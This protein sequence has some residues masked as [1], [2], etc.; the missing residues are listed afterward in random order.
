M[1][2]IGVGLRVV[3][4]AYT[5]RITRPNAHSS[6]RG[7]PSAAIMPSPGVAELLDDA[8]GPE[9]P[10]YVHPR[11]I[12][13]MGGEVVGDL[14]NDRIIRLTEAVNRLTGRYAIAAQARWLKDNA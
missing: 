9:R 11:G 4:A 10:P 12:A 14:H 7:T 8:G 13:S 1:I 5:R 6:D 3:V 2:R